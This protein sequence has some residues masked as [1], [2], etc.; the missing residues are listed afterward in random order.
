MNEHT[1]QH[2]P[3]YRH[4]KGLKTL[5]EVGPLDIEGAFQAHQQARHNH[6][7]AK[8]ICIGLIL[9]GL[10]LWSLPYWP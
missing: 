5:G 9:F 8:T 7:R 3:A 1:R 4:D 6:M 10:L 2:R